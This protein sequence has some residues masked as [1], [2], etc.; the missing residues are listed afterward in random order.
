[1]SPADGRIGIAYRQGCHGVR[2]ESPRCQVLLRMDAHPTER[3]KHEEHDRIMNLRHDSNS[4]RHLQRWAYSCLR[5]LIKES[6]AKQ[7]NANVLKELKR[8]DESKTEEA[9]SADST[10]TEAQKQDKESPKEAEDSEKAA[11]NLETKEAVTREESETSSAK[12]TASPEEKSKDV[13]DEKK[14]EHSVE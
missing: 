6:P 5:R 9:K 4:S 3:K 8:A 11:K 7:E 14:A 10:A 12:P 1:D 2:S 13:N